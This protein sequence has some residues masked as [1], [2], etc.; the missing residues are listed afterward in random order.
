MTSTAAPTH[1]PPA[2]HPGRSAA[3]LHHLDALRAGALLLGIVLHS[4]MPFLPGL[5]WIVEDTQKSEFMWIVMFVIH[6]FRMSLFMMLAGY[7]G[8]MV[9]QRRGSGAYLKD[10]ALR[11]GLPLIAFWPIAVG[12]LAVVSIIAASLYGISTAAEVDPDAAPS[13]LTLFTPGQLWFLLVLL[14]IAV[15]VVAVRAVLVKILGAERAG[16][17][18][19]GIGSLIASPFGILIAAAYGGAFLVGW[20]LHADAGSLDRIQKRWMP[21]LVLALVTSP[22][23]FVANGVTGSLL[24]E[25][26]LHALAGWAWVFALMGIC[27]RLITGPVGWVRYLADASYWMYLLH[28]PVLGFLEIPLVEL[29]WPIVAKLLVTW[30]VTTAIL[31][32]SYDLFV[33]STW[34]GKWLNGHRRERA[35]FTRRNRRSSAQAHVRVGDHP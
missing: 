25:S 27:A 9:L 14:E 18:S 16:R 32:L 29:G 24:A 2:P 19:S 21:Y 1:V 5:P 12:S 13:L 28:M 17:I 15:V 4:V 10:R 11:I 22:L 34:I 26:V 3:R 20:F 30:V 35:L 7:F 33:R 8:R 31:L 6:L 23:A